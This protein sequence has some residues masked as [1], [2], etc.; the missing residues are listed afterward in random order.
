MK[1]KKL[2]SRAEFLDLSFEFESFLQPTIFGQKSAPVTI[3]WEDL[4]ARHLNLRRKTFGQNWVFLVL[5]ESLE[6]HFGRP[7]KKC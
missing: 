7:N 2:F 5:C 6:I 3:I 4:I 1:I